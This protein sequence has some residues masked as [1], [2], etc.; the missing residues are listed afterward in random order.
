[1]S[2][3]TDV[4]QVEITSLSHIKGQDKV[5]DVLRVNLDAYFNSRQNGSGA[6][7]GP[8]L[9]VGPSGTG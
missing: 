2:A 1:M 6:N 8:A 5:V 9:L 7:F 3:G 4:N